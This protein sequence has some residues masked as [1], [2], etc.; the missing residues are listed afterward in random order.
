MVGPYDVEMYLLDRAN[1][2]DTIV[3]MV[4]DPLLHFSALFPFSGAPGIKE[5][6]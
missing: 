4:R 3:R 6:R 1:I 5:A 2:Q